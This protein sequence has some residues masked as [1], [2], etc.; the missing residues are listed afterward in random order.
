[1]QHRLNAALAPSA[2]RRRVAALAVASALAPTGVAHAFEIDTGN[3]D[4]EV[5][6]DNTVRYNLGSRVGSVGL[7]GNN[8]NFD[9]GE[10]KFD[11]G[12]IVTNRFDLL[13]EMD[14]VY[15]KKYGFRV[16]GAAWYDH[17]YS[18]AKARRNPALAGIP[19]SYVNDD[20]TSYTRR[21]YK[22]SGELLDAFV[23]GRFDLGE[24]PVNVKAGRHTV[25]WGE[26]VLLGGA[27]H[28]ISYSQMPL[29]L[30]KGFANPGA[31]AK[32]LFRPL[33]SLSAQA[34]LTSTL[35]LAAQYF[36]QWENS[37]FPEGGT[38]LGPADFAFEG[39]QQVS[40]SVGLLPNAGVSKPK[41]ERGEL[42]LA[43]RWNPDWLDGTLGFFYRNFTDKIPGALAIAGA[44]PAATNPLGLQYIQYYG[45]DTDMYGVSLSKSVAGVSLGL[46][47]SYR[48]NQQL[49]NQTLGNT[50]SVLIGPLAALRPFLFPNGPANV[51]LEGNTQ[52]ARGNTWHAVANAFGV[53]S[54][55]PLFDVA[56]YVAELTY[57]KLDKVTA[58]QDMYF[59]EGYGV[60]RTELTNP[61]LPAVVRSQY[62]D[63]WDGC[64]TGS[65]FG[66]GINFTP[67]WFQ[68]YPGVDLSAPL[69]WSATL[70]GN[71]PVAFGGNEKNGNYAVGLALDVLQKYRFDLKYVDYYG[72]VKTGTTAQGLQAVTSQNGFTTLL[73]DRGFVA[74]TF[75]TTF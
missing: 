25:Y 34:Q 74:L 11:R 56:T 39:P 37:R 3:A 14:V 28:G 6:W 35:S 64:S 18:D 66:V 7:V 24:V 20:F 33:N 60:C 49:L 2:L 42:G 5:R 29:D 30:Q 67:T 63:K 36:L 16:S 48:K 72:K 44:T 19:G 41:D 38:F 21:Y 54:S 13:S 32:E 70:N 50:P 9:E 47:V 1:M 26:S 12:D 65:H 62:R 69:A 71:S 27:L 73:K 46:D 52:A 57:S 53:V 23:F 40:T 59:G 75:K 22:E 43:V 61:A 15:R 58:N 55:T 4:V 51:T 17:A 45:E 31:E 68:V 8:P 10:H